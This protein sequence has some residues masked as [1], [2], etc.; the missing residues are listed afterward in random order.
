[1]DLLEIGDGWEFL[2]Y[3]LSVILFIG[4]VIDS[5]DC[6]M[7]AFGFE[8]FL[9]VSMSWYF[10]LARILLWYFTAHFCLFIKYTS[11]EIYEV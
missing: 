5:I 9:L 11:N 2:Y 4:G 1:M 3:F 10:C 8:L 6:S 7:G